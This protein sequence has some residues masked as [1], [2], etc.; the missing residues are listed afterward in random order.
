MPLYEYECETCGRRFEVIRKFS[1][2]PLDAC[3][4]C[5][6]G[7]VKRLPSS[8]AIQF[9]GSGF[10]ITDYAKKGETGKADRMSA[11]QK[12]DAKSDAAAAGKGTKTEGKAEGTTE[13]KTEG[14]NKV[15][16]KGKN[17]GKYKGKDEGKDKGEKTRGKRQGKT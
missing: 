6:S 1:D 3:T 14:K 9:K 17:K 12:Q 16:N 10:Y 8:P 13:G 15:K 7:P 2:P 4:Q 5:G 11:E